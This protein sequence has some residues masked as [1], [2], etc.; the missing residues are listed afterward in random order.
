[1]SRL[2]ILALGDA[3]FESKNI[4]EVNIYLSKLKSFLTEHGDDID[5]C[6]IMGDTL[7]EHERLHV[8]PFNKALE[9]IKLLSEYKP[10]YVIVGNHDMQN[11]SAF[12]TAEHWVECIRP[13]PNVT[14]VDNVLIEELKGYKVIFSPYV[15]EGRF[16]EALE[17]ADKNW[18]DANL[19]LS[20]VDIRGANMGSIISKNADE[21][22]E[23]YPML[24]SGHI[25]LSQ[26]LGKNMY[27]TGSIM[28]VAIDEPSNK[29]ICIVSISNNSCLPVINEFDLKLPKK[30]II[31][32]DVDDID[33]YI[34]PN[35]EETKYT[36]YLSGSYEEFKSFRK[37][38]KYKDLQKLPQLQKIRY[39]ANKLDV[40]TNTLKIEELK[41]KKIKNFKELLFD[42]INTENDELLLS[43]Y[44]HLIC[45][46]NTDLS[47]K[48]D[49]VIILDKNFYFPKDI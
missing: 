32:L 11:Q 28:Q 20:H 39:K 35:E 19:I 5:F 24:V 49:E 25:H 26:W 16:V 36:L 2:N 22:K 33:N 38:N 45:N 3:H 18:K 44:N 21:W 10:T 46:D 48:I 8:S 1:M 17:L 9:Y 41:N 13:Y 27:Y 6:C 4:R 43:F 31:H 14:I 30:E 37:S 47:N 42:S 12:L 15:P 34:L 7:H 40:K 23:D 29:H